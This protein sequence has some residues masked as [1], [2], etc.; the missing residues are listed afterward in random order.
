[1]NQ[2]NLVGKFK[3][4]GFTPAVNK[5]ELDEMID[6][7]IKYHGVLREKLKLQLYEAE[8]GGEKYNQIRDVS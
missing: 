3:G 4:L 8:F 7:I 1:M 5:D 2:Q 6:D